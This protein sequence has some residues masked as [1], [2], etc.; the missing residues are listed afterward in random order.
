MTPSRREE[1]LQEALDLYG[2]DVQMDIAIEEM[3]ELTKA[4]IKNRRHG[5]T[6][7]KK[8]ILEEACDVYIMVRQILIIFE[9][10]IGKENVF[11]QLDK[12][13]LKLEKGMK[14]EKKERY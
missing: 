6:I 8:R 4:I 2:V 7:T 11:K 1:I 13:L 5:T 12:K 10:N 3:A 14:K 9:G